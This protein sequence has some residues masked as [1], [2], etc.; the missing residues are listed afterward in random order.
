MSAPFPRSPREQA[1]LDWALR[2]RTAELDEQILASSLVNAEKA[3]NASTPLTAK[4]LGETDAHADR[5][6]A[7]L[8][9]RN[10]LIRTKGDGAA[11]DQN[12]VMLAVAYASHLDD[13]KALIRDGVALAE[14][15]AFSY[16]DLDRALSSAGLTP[17]QVHGFHQDLSQLL[18]KGP[19]GPEHRYGV[20][21]QR[22]ENK[23]QPAVHRLLM[24]PAVKQSRQA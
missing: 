17:Q 6:A 15:H 21:F 11:H 23:Q 19:Q 20:S 24:V 13:R 12:Q 18:E 7:E 3:A 14:K 1:L 8:A 22:V 2:F 4:V 9:A 10:Q 16:G 5:Q